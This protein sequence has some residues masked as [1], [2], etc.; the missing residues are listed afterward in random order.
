MSLLSALL[1]NEHTG[2]LLIIQW[3]HN[4]NHTDSWAPPDPA[5]SE[6]TG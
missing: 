2:T 3:F 5:N 4:L 1:D 6:A